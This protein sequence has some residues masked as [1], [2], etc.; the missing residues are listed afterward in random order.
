M[1]APDEIASLKAVVTAEVRQAVAALEKVADA[2]DKTGAGADK[3]KEKSD[4]F[5]KSL[6][7]FEIITGVVDQV[8]GLGEAALSSY[9]DTERL[10]LSLEALVAKEKVAAGAYQDVQQAMKA[11]GDEAQKLLKWTQ[12]LAIDSPFG[13]DGVAEAFKMAQ[14]YGFVSDSMDKTQI[15]AKRLTSA[16][17]DFSA[18]SGQSEETMQRVSLALGQVKAKGKLA[19]DEMMQLTEAGLNARQ[20]LADAFHKSTDEIVRMQEKGLI[21]ADKAIKAITESLE[22]DFG[23]AA[24][25]QAETFSGLLN[26]LDDLKSVSLKN[27]FGGVFEGLKPQIVE[28]VNL[29][30]SDGM[31]GTI[32]AVG[33]TA[34]S[35]VSLISSNIKTLI[36]VIAGVGAA[37]IGYKVAQ[38]AATIAETKKAIVTAA[39]SAAEAAQTAILFV[40]TNGLRA[41]TTA[42]Y[43]YVVAGKSLALTLGFVAA[44]A[45]AVTAAIM[46]YQEYQQQLA[47]SAKGVLEN[48]TAWKQAAAAQD[49]YNN[50]SAST[51]SVLQG[52]IDKLKQLKAEQETATQSLAGDMAALAD[53]SEVTKQAVYKR[54]MAVVND[55]SAKIKDQAQAIRDVTGQERAEEIALQRA[56]GTRQQATKLTQEQQQALEKLA[57]AG[58]KAY[59][60]LIQTGASFYDQEQSRA[61]DHRQKLARIGADGAKGLADLERSTAEQRRQNEEKY[62]EQIADLFKSAAEQRQQDEK[63]YQEAAAERAEAHSGRL[64]DIAQKGL[65]LQKNAQEEAAA[66]VEEYSR[67]RAAVEERAAEEVAS[68]VARE[69]ERRAQVEERYRDQQKEAAAGHEQKLVELAEKAADLRTDAARSAADVAQRYTEQLAETA[70]RYADKMADIEQRFTDRKRDLQESAQEGQQDRAESHQERL[71]EL[72]KGLAEARTDVEYRWAQEAIAAENERYQKEEQRA[73]EKLQKELARAEE[74]RQRAETEAQQ[75]RQ[76]QEERAAKERAAAEAQAAER[77]A[78]REAQLAKERALEDT[79]YQ[80]RDALRAAQFAKDRAEDDAKAAADLAA[81]KAQADKELARLA[82]QFDREKAARAEKLDEARAKLIE[83]TAEENREYQKREQKARQ[84]YDEQRATFDAKQAEALAAAQQAHAKDEAELARHYAEAKAQQQAAIADRLAAESAAYAEQEKQAA[85]QHAR[86]EQEQLQAL[87]RSLIAYTEEQERQ[88]KISSEQGDKLMA[89]LRQRY[90]VQQSLEEAAYAKATA[91]ID[92]YGKDTGSSLAGVASALDGVTQGA[93][94]QQRVFDTTLKASIDR[95]A[96]QFVDGKVGIQDYAQALRDIPNKIQTELE[97]SL[98][99]RGGEAIQKYVDFKD[100][101]ADIPGRAAGGPVSAGTLYQVN[102]NRTEYFLPS[103]DGQVLPLA[104]SAPPAAGGSSGPSLN[105]T[106]SI[107]IV[108][109]S[110]VNVNDP[111]GLAL[112]IRDELLHIGKENGGSIFGGLA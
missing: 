8:K 109:P 52:N 54:G 45:V 48:S 86:Q 75:E 26:S 21:P 12:Q 92:Q 40:K 95:V 32:T 17:I 78:L 9:A 108:L 18:G 38:E 90:G 33:K 102:E 22:R 62:Q 88:G 30:G 42:T 101:Q 19:G 68:I 83:E 57:S 2:F 6:L 93:I 5:L 15:T 41:A 60:A 25:R 3:G 70:Q 23:G 4:S 20:I 79:G 56:N 11:S 53:A 27:L 99:A 96:K 112:K 110:G 31:Q 28:V 51:Q 73:Q 61:V 44:A 64:A 29:L 13:Q 107:S 80:E 34:G 1:S 100:R 87:G 36:P 77:L 10:G 67:K 47:D 58:E 71:V 85:L 63:S 39:V 65:E 49:A 43:E 69:A 105:I 7:K 72:E 106:G 50:A 24:K 82:E 16:L 74:Q 14:A 94:T 46:K 66:E 91:V 76:R 37:W 98:L 81:K 59:G 104:P 111:R 89:D 103:V 97:L 84:H 55:Y 35:V